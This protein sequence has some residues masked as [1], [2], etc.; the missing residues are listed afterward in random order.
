MIPFYRDVENREQVIK[1]ILVYLKAM[2][3]K[4]QLDV[5][6]SVR[7][8]PGRSLS[9]FLHTHLL[10]EPHKSRSTLRQALKKQLF[11]LTKST[12]YNRAKKLKIASNSDCFMATPCARRRLTLLRTNGIY[13]VQLRF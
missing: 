4:N 6:K 9:G 2:K 1:S 5:K 7:A 3:Q 8:E 13:V 12:I 11:M 10:G